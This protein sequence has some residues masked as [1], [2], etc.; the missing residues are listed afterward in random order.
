MQIHERLFEESY[1]NGDMLKKAKI[2]QETSQMNEFTFSPIRKAAN[3]KVVKERAENSMQRAERLYSE[4][5]ERSRKLEQ[6]RKQRD[7]MLDQK[8]AQ[9]QNALR[10]ELASKKVAGVS[11]NYGSKT[12]VQET[13]HEKDERLKNLQ[14]KVAQESGITFKPVLITKKSSQSKKNL[15][16][17]EQ[18]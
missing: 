9:A 5:A 1:R 11:S 7:Y 18:K 17:I 13:Q 3:A 12:A 6:M 16:E 2:E 15:R 14:Q 4:W 8:T 10:D